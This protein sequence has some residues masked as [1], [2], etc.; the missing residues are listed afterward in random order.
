MDSTHILEE[1]EALR[2]ILNLSPDEEVPKDL[3]KAVAN[4]QRMMHGAG[5]TG[6]IEPFGLVLLALQAGYARKT[7]TVKNAFRKVKK[8]TRVKWQEKY[9]ETWGLFQFVCDAPRDTYCRVIELGDHSAPRDIEEHRLTIAEDAEPPEAR[10]VD[11]ELPFNPGQRVIVGEEQGYFR[12]VSPTGRI[13]VEL[14]RVG[15][16]T[17]ESFDLEEVRAFDTDK[18]AAEEPKGWGTVQSGHPCSFV[19]AEGDLEDAVFVR[20][21]GEGKVCLRVIETDAE[22][23]V[24]TDDVVLDSMVTIDG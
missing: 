20:T 18:D 7:R 19:T 6:R 12:A 2:G 8:N 11:E 5:I 14:N 9:R 22:I 10:P 15:L 24:D 16:T 13:R 1:L 21:D 23:V 17:L 4:A 3:E